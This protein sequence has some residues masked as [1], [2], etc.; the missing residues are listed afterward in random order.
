MNGADPSARRSLR[1]VHR[2]GRHT[3]TVRHFGREGTLKLCGQRSYEATA[4]RSDALIP[5][6]HD[7][8]HSVEMVLDYVE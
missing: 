2:S 7:D 4:L 8:L 5:R 6:H 3:D 1:P